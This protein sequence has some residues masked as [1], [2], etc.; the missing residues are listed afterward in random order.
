MTEE[1]IRT[2][3]Q[4][5]REYHRHYN[6]AQSVM[7]ACCDLVG[8]TCAEAIQ[9]GHPFG[10]GISGLREIC[11]CVSGMAILAG[12]LIPITAGSDP[13]AKHSQRVLVQQ[14]AQMFRHENGDIVCARLKDP[15]LGCAMIS[16]D[17][18]IVSAIKI[19]CMQV[20]ERR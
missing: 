13:A 19:F 6:C 14:M 11:G 7:L 18:L 1:E 5:G 4:Q 15:K 8:M 16:C 2:R 10:N 9:W 20:H 3:M 12:K 17:E